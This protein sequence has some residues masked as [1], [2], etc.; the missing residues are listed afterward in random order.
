MGKLSNPKG[1]FVKRRKRILAV[2]LALVMIM[3]NLPFGYS[4]KVQAVDGQFAASQSVDGITVSVTADAGVFPQGVALSVSKVNSEAVEQ[5]VDGVRA[6]NVNVVSSYTFDIKVLDADGNEI[7]PDTSKGSVKVSFA[8]A[9]VVNQNL[10]VE[11]YHIADENAGAEKLDS[12]VQNVDGEQAVVAETT[13]FS[14]YTVEFTYNSL[15]YVL[16]GDSTVSLATI[17]ETVGLTGIVENAVSSNPDLFSVE[18][19]AEGEDWT[20]SAKQAFTSN[21]TLKVTIDGTEYVITVTDDVPIYVG[22]SYYSSTL[23]I[24]DNSGECRITDF[25]VVSMQSKTVKINL[26][27][28][29]ENTDLLEL[30]IPE[31]VDIYGQEFTVVGIDNNGA[32]LWSTCFPNLTTLKFPDSM[33]DDIG[34]LYEMSKLTNIHLPRGITTLPSF[35]KCSSLVSL[36]LS[37]YTSLTSISNNLFAGCTSLDKVIF[38]DNY[39]PT[40]KEFAECP[41]PLSHIDISRFP[42]KLPQ[43]A[44]VKC[45][46]LK[47]IT[48]PA[49]ITEIGYEAFA[50]CSSLKAVAFE[51][52]VKINS[53][54]FSGCSN[55]VAVISSPNGT[56]DGYSE[57]YGDSSAVIYGYQKEKYDWVNSSDRYRYAP[58]LAIDNTHIASGEEL[59]GFL[60]TPEVNYSRYFY[61][62][63][64]E[65]VKLYVDGEYKQ[66]ITSYAKFSVSGLSDGTHIL[67]ARAVFEGC[68][69]SCKGPE[70]TVTVGQ[71]L[72]TNSWETE[73]SIEGWTYGETASTPV[74]AATSGENVSFTYSDSATGTYSATKPTD[75]GTYY[76]K[77]TVAANDT[78]SGLES[79]PISFKIARAKLTP[80][81]TGTISKVYD[82][83]TT[84][85]TTDAGISLT[86]AKNGENPTAT[87]SFA[88][89][90]ADVDTGITV[91]A[92]DITLG[93]AWTTNY[94]LT[95]TTANTTGTITQR[96]VN[97][98][99][100]SAGSALYTGKAV[101]PNIAIAFTSVEL[102]KDSDY[103][104]ENISNNINV[105]TDTSKASATIKGI[106][107]FAGE[108]TIEFDIKRLQTDVEGIINGDSDWTNG[109]AGLSA[110]EGFQIT[111]NADGSG[112]GK[113][114]GTSEESL[115]LAGTELTYYLVQ[116]GTGAISEAK[117]KT[118]K[119][120]RTAPKGEIKISTKGWDTFLETIT[121][122]RYKSNTKTVTITGTDALSGVK[123]VKYIV[124]EEPL[125]KF[126]V[127]YESHLQDYTGSFEIDSNKKQIIYAVIRDNAGNQCEISSDGIILDD[128]APVIDIQSFK[129]LDTSITLS[130][131]TDEAGSYWAY[132]YE[133][134]TESSVI[135]EAVIEKAQKTGIMTADADG[136]YKNELTFT[137]LS[138][139]TGYRI[140]IVTQDNVIDIATGEETH[141]VTKW[142]DMLYIETTTEKTIPIFAR[143]PKFA[144]SYVYGTSLSEMTVED[145]A[146]TNGVAGTWTI[147]ESNQNRY[148]IVGGTAAWKVTFTPNDSNYSTVDRYIIPV[149]TARDISDESLVTIV[150]EKDNDSSYTPVYTGNAIEM[151]ATV[152]DSNSALTMVKDT[153]Y[154]FTYMNNVNAMLETDMYPPILIIT[155]KGNYT[156][157]VVKAYTIAKAEMT[158]VSVAQSGTLTYKPTADHKGEAQTPVVD[159]SATTVNNQTISV[160]YSL[161]ENGTYTSEV[162]K[163]TKADD[164]TVY[165]KVSAPNHN[166]AT[167]SFEVKMAKAVNP[168]SVPEAT[169]TV[170][171]L[172]KTVGAVALPDGWEWTEADKNKELSVETALTANAVYT[173][174]DKDNFETL[175]TVAITLTRSRCVHDGEVDI[176][177]FKAA[178]TT[179][180]GYTGDKHCKKCDELLESGTVIPKIVASYMVTASVDFDAINAG[181]DTPGAKTVTIRN[182]G[183]C[184]LVLTQPGVA[185]YEIGTLSKTALAPNEE[186]TFTIQP[187]AGLTAGS[188]EADI[189]IS[190]AY[191]TSNN[192]TANW[193]E[194]KNG[195]A[196]KKVTAK[197]TVNQKLK[198][199]T[200][201]TQHIFKSDESADEV[202]FSAIPEAGSGIYTYKWYKNNGTEVI[203]TS[204]N[205]TASK[206]DAPAS[207]KVVLSDGIEEKEATVTTKVISKHTITFDT[208][209]GSSVVAIAAYEDE[210]ITAP[211]NPT[212]TGY[213]F[214]G[215]NQTI[216]GKMPD[217]DMTI[218]A[219]WKLIP[220]YTILASFDGNETANEFG[221]LNE[222]YETPSDTKTITV[223]NTGNQSVTLIQPT[224]VSYELGTLSKT[225][226]AVGET[227]TFTIA[228]KTGLLSG[229]HQETIRIANTQG[230][231]A[232]VNVNVKVNG[233][234]MVSI[235]PDK[236]SIVNGE[237][238]TLTANVTGGSGNYTYKWYEGAATEEVTGSTGNTITV[239][240]TKATTY[241]VVVNDTI[242]DKQA[243][244]TI[245]VLYKYTITFDTDR[246]SEISPITEV[247]GRSIKA[248]ANPTKDG[249]T[250]NG[251]NQT[252]PEVMP[253]KDMT[254]KAQWKEVTPEPAEY[255]IISGDGSE[256]RIGADGTIT[257][258]CDGEFSKFVGIKMDGKDVDASNYTAKAGSTVVTF[259]ASYLNKLSAGNH[260]V[261]F[262]YTDGS[263]DATIKNIKK[264]SSDSDDPAPEQPTPEHPT[265]EQ[266]TA[267]QPTAERPSTDNSGNDKKFPKTGDDF[268]ARIWMLLMA[269]GL[270]GMLGITAYRKKEK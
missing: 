58:T 233:T 109:W 52:T 19:N 228:P 79:A 95:S 168:Y 5:S 186:A 102:I 220:V 232:S 242:E 182:T 110:P 225:E 131:E 74:A 247:E 108:K 82:G 50:D 123:S 69:I 104:V 235:A 192:G 7:Q 8:A 161:E 125:S 34:G 112:A 105:T 116:E 111:G 264:S 128:V 9:E 118:V 61:F 256:H 205:V 41:G 106:G 113:S 17:L 135:V 224:A 80:S 246:G 267:V 164:Y 24:Y 38:P 260:T 185:N 207:Y 201:K 25:T 165:Y 162:P 139:N 188:Y 189:T 245:T 117:T 197:F 114:Y 221:S 56:I 103:T 45:T 269:L 159:A 27:S 194:I 20:V 54:A 99:T 237:S 255:K 231:A 199:T 48:I 66:D 51:G 11:V 49:N 84:V 55:L 212:K 87:A 143:D 132:C 171:Y 157:T 166:D 195:T 204:A 243:E 65:P 268:D 213:T 36:D 77:A 31:K 250:F 4:Y 13:G 222:G 141:N 86:G 175:P 76:M 126:K 239:S 153:D 100:V 62:D 172:T 236:A 244:A 208:D 265:T 211:A 253:S 46:G 151:T 226:L 190:A 147:T 120:D 170:P 254:L 227:A 258:K 71:V 28:R 93:S 270:S 10:D 152:T 179:E 91:N 129:A 92:T 174:E 183:N 181:M 150:S 136:K 39:T 75:A 251:W 142:E 218:T 202:T 200:D 44:F 230:Q 119:I 196:S 88:Y 26:D 53:Y 68:N 241:K 59:F 214:N 30:T 177:N 16:D 15:Q 122:G 12:S 178:T 78:Y 18:K 3:G 57:T 124:S 144:T 252:F 180:D 169:M 198:I 138:P 14:Y 216:P 249:Y 37:N 94:E 70:L 149:I 115:S 154:T 29:Y 155:G 219:K 158:D 107:N 140:A 160:T 90:G 262:V 215:W 203:S 210:A 73:P 127:G 67:Q 35:Q 22:G 42:S 96:D 257:I 72:E 229:T 97:S 43:S 133:A 163:V 191:A 130:F 234:L 217:H 187:K 137:D 193:Q 23:E 98:C 146:S 240:P 266:P 83:T 1:E 47:E 209:G 121:F 134:G 60:S 184:D 248:P 85:E 63:R 223:T 173:A 101:T 40:G 32:R 167:G 21:E 33:V 238:Q 261:T 263:V 81:I 145:L 89:E 6:D 148:P 2:F 176:R 64:K 206:A 259:K 156:G